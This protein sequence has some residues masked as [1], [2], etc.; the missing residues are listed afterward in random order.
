[1]SKKTKIISAIIALVVAIGGYGGSQLIGGGGSTTVFQTIGGSVDNLCLMPKGFVD[2]TT[3]TTAGFA[4]GCVWTQ[5]IDVSGITDFTLSGEG[6]GEAGT[7][8]IFARF[9][10]SYDGT[11]FF[12]VTGN[13]TSTIQIGTSTGQLLIKAFDFDPGTA[14]TTFAYDFVIPSANVLRVQVYGEQVSD[15][16]GVQAFLQ[17]GFNQGF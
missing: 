16:V 6:L 1:M 4:E 3:T 12:N 11:N 17:I 2:D 9:S 7:S 8:T 14:S 5:D 15:E 13:S 10:I